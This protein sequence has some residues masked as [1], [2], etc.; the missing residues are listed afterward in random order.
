[1]S[2]GEQMEITAKNIERL[3]IVEMRWGGRSARSLRSPKKG[4]EVIV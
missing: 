2:L 4:G 3:V 1:M